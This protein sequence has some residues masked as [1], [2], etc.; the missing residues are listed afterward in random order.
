MSVKELITKLGIIVEDYN[1]KQDYNLK[2]VNFIIDQDDE[3]H[4]YVDVKYI[5]IYYDTK[6]VCLYE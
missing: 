5:S 1:D 4:S 6:E 3:D 2:I